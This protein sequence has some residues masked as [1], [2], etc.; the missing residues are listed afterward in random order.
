MLRNTDSIA[1]RLEWW[2][3]H[4][5]ENK[6]NFIFIYDEFWWRKQR[7][8]MQVFCVNW[9]SIEKLSEKLKN[10]I[11]KFKHKGNTIFICLKEGKWNKVLSSH[12][13]SFFY[14]KNVFLHILPYFLQFK[15]MYTIRDRKRKFGKCWVFEGKLKFLQFTVLQMECEKKIIFFSFLDKRI[16][17]N[18]LSI[19]VYLPYAF[20]IHIFNL[21]L[22][23]SWSEEFRIFPGL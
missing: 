2:K 8:K 4:F 20:T 12:H 17:F 11:S 16:K 5:P 23:P 6:F 15:E 7:T 18:L 1:S 10:K 13:R 9:K 22:S 3:M 14:Y 19:P 21:L